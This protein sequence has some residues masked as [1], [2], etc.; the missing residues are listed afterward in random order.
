MSVDE[1]KELDLLIST[2]KVV[3]LKEFLV[4]Q[5][6]LHERAL[7]VASKEMNRRLE[8]MNEV[9]DQLNRQ[10]VTF[11]T[12]DAHDAVHQALLLSINKLNLD[13][14]TLAGKASM[15]YIYISWLLAVIAIAV[16]WLK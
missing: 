7:D 8:S 6:Y 9:R 10:A 14:A 13:A 12:K 3:T 2:G 15:T 11:V 5:L 4:S 16:A 1:L